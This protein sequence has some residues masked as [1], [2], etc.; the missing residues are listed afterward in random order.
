MELRLDEGKGEPLAWRLR[1]AALHSGTSH[2]Q[3]S[4]AGQLSTTQKLR[5]CVKKGQ[6]IE[7][8]NYPLPNRKG[9][10]EDPPRS[11]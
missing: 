8:E 2:D 9:S 7:N 1:G 10:S 6:S 3:L 4:A 5:V 11:T